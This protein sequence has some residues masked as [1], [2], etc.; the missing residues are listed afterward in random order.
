MKATLVSIL[1]ALVVLSATVSPARASSISLND[2]FEAGAWANTIQNYMQLSPGSTALTGWAIVEEVVWG[3]TLTGDGHYAA[4]GDYFLDLSS[5]GATSVG[6]IEQVL[7]TTPGQGYLVSLAS[8][9]VIAGIQVDGLGLAPLMST[10][11]DSA[12]STV[13]YFFNA[14]DSSTVLRVYNPLPGYDIIF[15]DDLN[16]TPLDD[17]PVPEPLSMLLVGSGL[18]GL[19]VRRRAWGRTQ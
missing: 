14:V 3:L 4:Q 19:I 18:A 12:W 16:V 13:M 17:S 10:P 5:F 8:A 6:A 15:V 1:A 9:G 2:S 11:I 7:S